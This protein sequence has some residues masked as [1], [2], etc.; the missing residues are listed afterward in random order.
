MPAFRLDL[1]RD[2]FHRSSLSFVADRRPGAQLVPAIRAPG[3][4][5]GS[6]NNSLNR[7]SGAEN[8]TG[9]GS[10]DEVADYAAQLLGRFSPPYDDSS[11]GRTTSRGRLMSST[12]RAYV[13]KSA[14]VT[15]TVVTQSER[16]AA[17]SIHSSNMSD[18]HTRPSP[19]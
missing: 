8:C 16:Q 4:L 2:H 19:E 6:F 9:S 3:V 18:P 14:L 17:W 1:P 7:I 15:P 5:S 10:S 11:S 13:T 12:N